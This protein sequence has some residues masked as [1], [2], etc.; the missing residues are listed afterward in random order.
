M[1]RC[2]F[3]KVKYNKIYYTI[4]FCICSF[5]LSNCK[6]SDV[7]KVCMIT[8]KKS[9]WFRHGFHVQWTASDEQTMDLGLKYAEPNQR[10]ETKTFH[11]RNGVPMFSGG[12]LSH[13]TLRNYHR[14][15]FAIPFRDHDSDA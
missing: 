5:L 14:R 2:R 3:C 8:K 11:N 13:A 1:L 10:Y 9:A 6:I 7:I 15:S 12:N 4:F